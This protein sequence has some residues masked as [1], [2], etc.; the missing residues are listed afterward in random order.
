MLFNYSGT[1]KPL[2]IMS[3]PSDPSVEKEYE[4]LIRQWKTQL[5]EQQPAVPSNCDYV[6]LAWMRLMD[7]YLDQHWLDSKQM[8]QCAQAWSSRESIGLAEAVH[9]MNIISLKFMQRSLDARKELLQALGDPDFMA[10]LGVA[11]INNT[12]IEQKP[13]PAGLSDGEE[14]EEDERQEVH[15]PLLV[16]HNNSQTDHSRLEIDID[17]PV[18]NDEAIITIGKINENIT[19]QAR[20]DNDDVIDLSTY[21]D[22]SDE[23]TISPAFTSYSHLKV[24][25]STPNMSTSTNKDNLPVSYNGLFRRHESCYQQL[26]KISSWKEIQIKEE[27]DISE[28][29]SI[30]SSLQNIGNKSELCLP[31]FDYSTQWKSWFSG[32][33]IDSIICDNPLELPVSCFTEFS[34]EDFANEKIETDETFSDLYLALGESKSSGIHKPSLMTKSESNISTFRPISNNLAPRCHQAMMSSPIPNSMKRSSSCFDHINDSNLRLPLYS[35]EHSSSNFFSSTRSII[36][37]SKSFP[38]KTKPS[39]EAPSP[40]PLPQKERKNMIRSIVNKKVSFS[41]LFGSKKGSSSSSTT[42]ASR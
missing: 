11:P 26:Y 7:H 39:A 3:N 21:D 33:Q 1:Q 25:L 12:S 5:I 16:K 14:D 13:T 37:K 18:R 22:N 15:A 29:Q 6:R 17:S 35:N 9:T 42:T 10:S 28:N 32:K 23:D 31:A 24:S 20:I 2:S 40:L 36:T 27:D 34:G 30:Y 38:S 8:L 41:K 19:D 4:A